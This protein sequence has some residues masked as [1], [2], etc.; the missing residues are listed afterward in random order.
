MHK[1][2][3]SNH[4]VIVFTERYTML[5]KAVPKQNTNGITV[6][7]II[8]AHQIANFGIPSELRIDDGP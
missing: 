1:S 5:T 3:Q 6:S 7:L 8:L 2:K 4:V